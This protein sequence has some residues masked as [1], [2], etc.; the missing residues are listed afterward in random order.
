MTLISQSVSLSSSQTASSTTASTTSTATAAGAT[1]GAFNQTLT[2]MM[3]GGQTDSAGTDANGSPLVM[4]LPLI[5]TGESTEA[6]TEPLVETLA[7]LLQNLEKL[8][9]QVAADP[10]LLASLQ[11]WI[12]QVQQFLQ[13]DGTNQQLNGGETSEATGLTA[14]AITR[15][16]FDLHCRTLCH[17]LPM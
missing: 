17:N 6:P 16:L 14:L 3:T 9:D 2:Q 8:D 4:V 1:T 5:A 7:P 12:Q 10:A 15:L 13:G 11:A